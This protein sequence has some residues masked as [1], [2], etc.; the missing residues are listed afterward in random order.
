MLAFALQAY[1][2]SWRDFMAWFGLLS[3]II[4]SIELLTG[5]VI[6]FFPPKKLARELLITSLLLLLL[7][8]GIGSYA[9]L[10]GGWN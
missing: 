5:I 2:P 3:L 4:G 6:L 1:Q 8:G 7:G 9:V 10:N